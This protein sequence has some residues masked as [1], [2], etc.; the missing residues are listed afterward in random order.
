MKKVKSQRNRH[1][2]R[3]NAAKLM[4]L[5]RGITS[6]DSRGRTYTSLGYDQAV[7]ASGNIPGYVIRKCMTVTGALHA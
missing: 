3:I 2:G 5:E 4:V 6:T 7:G 1:T